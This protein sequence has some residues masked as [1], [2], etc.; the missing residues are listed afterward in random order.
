MQIY[1][2]CS[3]GFSGVVDSTPFGGQEEGRSQVRFLAEPHFIF[4]K[5][6]QST[7]RLLTHVLCKPVPLDMNFTT[8]AH[9]KEA[10]NTASHLLFMVRRS[11]CDSVHPTLLRLRE[12]FA[13]STSSRWNADASELISSWHSKFSMEKLIST[14]L[15]YSTVHPEPVYEGTRTDNCKDQAVFDEGAVPFLSVW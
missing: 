13:N 10:A 7:V 1:L 8:S 2:S 3:R 11:F 6:H 9:C 15:N 4:N 14:G 5:A 12:G